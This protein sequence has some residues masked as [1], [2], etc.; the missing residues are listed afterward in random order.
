VKPF[1][2]LLPNP[3]LATIAANFWPRHLEEW[4]YPVEAKLFHTEADVRILVHVQ[5]PLD[6]PKGEVILVHG[7]EGSSHSKYMLSLAQT[8]LEDGWT[9]HRTNIRTCGGTEFLCNTLYHAGLTNDLFA[10]IMDLDRQRRTPIYVVGFSL[11]GNQVLKLAGEMADTGRRVLGGVCAVSTPLDLRACCLQ[12]EERGNEVY[13]YWYTSH[14]LKRLRLRKQVLG[15]AIPWDGV[16]KL[17]T[18]YKIDDRITGPAF[19]FDGA[20]HYYQTQSAQAYLPKVAVPCLL[21]QSKDDP[22]IPFR[23]FEQ[24]IVRENRNIKLIATERGGHIGFLARN[25]PRFWVDSVIRDWLRELGN[26]QGR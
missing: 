25:L 26:N 16:E 18:L 3:H 1:F 13:Q 9:V 22:M 4:R 7:L 20:D 23:V 5:R 21:V 15:D 11:G 6:P 19:G 8:L 12:L 10:Y 2:P 24:P 17:K 14:M